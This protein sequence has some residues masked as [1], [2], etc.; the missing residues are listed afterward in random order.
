MPII[1]SRSHASGL[2]HRNMY[3]SQ[4]P[5]GQEWNRAGGPGRLLAGGSMRYRSIMAGL[6]FCATGLRA[7]RHDVASWSGLLVDAGCPDRSPENLR[8][9][10]AEALAEEKPEK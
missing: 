4:Q 5:R 8:A 7:E 6:L 3:R 2:S 9:P 10:P 1:S